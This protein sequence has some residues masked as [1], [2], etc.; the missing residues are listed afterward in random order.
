M[1]QVVYRGSILAKNSQAYFLWQ[2]WQAAKVNRNVDQRKL[3]MHMKDVEQ[4]A[5][6]LLTRY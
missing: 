1:S 4:R 5:A 6:D 2:L 3:D